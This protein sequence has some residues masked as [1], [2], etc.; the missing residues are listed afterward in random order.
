MS[1]NKTVFFVEDD[2]DIFELIRSHLSSEGYDYKGFNNGN[3]FF[4]VLEKES[5]A[6]NLILLDI[7]LPDI[8]GLEI[9]KRVRAN[10]QT[11]KIPIIMLTARVEEI[12]KVLGLELGA[13]DYITKPFSPRELMARI[14]ALLRRVNEFDKISKDKKDILVIMNGRLKIDFNRCK[15]FHQNEEIK[16]TTTEF[17]LIAVL[18][19][20]K[21]RVM[22]RRQIL[23]NIWDDNRYVI[24]RTIDVHIRHLRTKLK[25]D[26]KLL[27]N[28]RGFGYKLS[29][30]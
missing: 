3:E 16:L 18:A 4:S 11:E 17:K 29:E 10:K 13:D 9:C 30:S 7:M 23:E 14:K 19:K 21:D 27:E 25:E 28:V 22:S 8:D 26:A 24:E 20:N 12:D 15:V 6:P 5:L 2:R 1:S